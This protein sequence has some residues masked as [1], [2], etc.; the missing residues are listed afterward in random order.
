MI[1]SARPLN[2][3]GFS[4]NL[5]RPSRSRTLVETSIYASDR[6]FSDGGIHSETLLRRIEAAVNDLTIWLESND[7]IKLSRIAS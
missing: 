6:D 7:A 5:R 4:G 1:A 3:V 2:I